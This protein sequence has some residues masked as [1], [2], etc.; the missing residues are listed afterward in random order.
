MQKLIF[1]GLFREIS[2][3]GKNPIPV[4][5][6]LLT[7]FMEFLAVEISLNSF[8]VRSDEPKLLH[9]IRGKLPGLTKLAAFLQLEAVDA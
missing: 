7:A 1:S 3:N 5:K 8:H 9:V 2:M 6:I 4:L